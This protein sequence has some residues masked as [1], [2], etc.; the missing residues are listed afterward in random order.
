MSRRG[1]DEVGGVHACRGAETPPH[2][3]QL[4]SADQHLAL[5][6]PLSLWRLGLHRRRP[7][8]DFKG[9]IVRPFPRLFSY[10][11]GLALASARRARTSRAP[12]DTGA[13]ARWWEDRLKR[14]TRRRPCVA[15]RRGY[16]LTKRGA[17]GDLRDSCG[18]IGSASRHA[19][20]ARLARGHRSGRS[21]T[22]PPSGGE[23]AEAGVPLPR[24]AHRSSG[25]ERDGL[26]EPLRA[27]LCRS[28][29]L[30]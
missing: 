13:E 4:V 28:T 30:T 5:F 29:S 23:F 11:E 20:S 15:P 2:V 24:R 19:V 17:A 1:R 8:D 12:W 6:S 7:S 16:S 25:D 26:A 21:P 18:G 27:C 14:G 22:D 10:C 3:R 9:H